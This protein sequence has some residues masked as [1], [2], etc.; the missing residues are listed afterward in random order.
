MTSRCLN[1]ADDP[2]R[3]AYLGLLLVE[4]IEELAAV[5]FGI[6]YSEKHGGELFD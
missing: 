1:L 3:A 6:S 5:L 2:V 4:E